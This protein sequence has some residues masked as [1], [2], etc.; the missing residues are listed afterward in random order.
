[1]KQLLAWTGRADSTI[2]SDAVMAMGGLGHRAVAVIAMNLITEK[3]A[4]NE[5][6]S[7]AT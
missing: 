1:M 7:R 2:T 6:G 3:A 5:C 4:K